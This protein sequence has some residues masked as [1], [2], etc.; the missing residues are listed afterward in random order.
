M[1]IVNRINKAREAFGMLSV[2]WRNNKFST[3]LK[4]RLFKSNVVSVLL[5]YIE[6]LKS[7]HIET[8]SFHKS[9]SMQYFPYLL[10]KSYYK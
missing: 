8:S 7:C 5:L 3:S 1:D 2:V 4:L 6:G 9:L 10:A